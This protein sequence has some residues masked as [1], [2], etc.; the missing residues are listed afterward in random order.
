MSPPSV[1]I[2]FSALGF[3]A[4]VASLMVS[5]RVTQKQEALFA[6]S[7]VD[8]AILREKVM[9]RD[10]WVECPGVAVVVNDTLILHSVLKGERRLPL[11]QITLTKETISLRSRGWW[12]KRMLH[13]KAPGTFRLAIGVKNPEPW[14][15]L[16]RQTLGT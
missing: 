16:F 3:L 2:L 14:R 13:L 12:R 1:L 11:S 8:G 10:G 6:A 9:I 15:H 7:E 4:I 5:R